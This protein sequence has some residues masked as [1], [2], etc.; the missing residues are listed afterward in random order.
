MSNVAAGTMMRAAAPTRLSKRF[1]AEGV[2]TS[3][4]TT[5]PF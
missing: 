2:I 4:K 5:K 3:E 1:T